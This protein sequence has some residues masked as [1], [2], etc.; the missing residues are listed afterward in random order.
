ML[1]VVSYDRVVAAY[2]FGQFPNCLLAVLLQ[3][4]LQ[5]IIVKLGESARAGAFFKHQVPFSRLTNYCWADLLVIALLPYIRRISKLFQPSFN[6]YEQYRTGSV[7][8][9]LFFFFEAFIFDK[10]F[11]ADIAQYSYRTM[12]EQKVPFWTVYQKLTINKG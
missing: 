10:L 6:V 2:F 3:K 4:C 8:N 12:I 11:R 7:K 9:V 5:I 1:K